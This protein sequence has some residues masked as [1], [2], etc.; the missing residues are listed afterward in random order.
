MRWRPQRVKS[1]STTKKKKKQDLES[2]WRRK[3]RLTVSAAC[4]IDFGRASISLVDENSRSHQKGKGCK[5]N[6]LQRQGKRFFQTNRKQEMKVKRRWQNEQKT[7]F[8]KYGL[9]PCSGFHFLN[10]IDCLTLSENKKKIELQASWNFLSFNVPFLLF[11]ILVVLYVMR[12]SE[13]T[14]FYQKGFGSSLGNR[15]SPGQ[16]WSRVCVQDGKGLNKITRGALHSSVARLQAVDLHV[17]CCSYACMCGSLSAGA[18][19]CWK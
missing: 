7:A 14:F 11:S 9:S 12:F 1:N 16:L 19:N 8:V 15:N 17:Y 3:E 5:K 4:R 6:P 10:F 18:S 2:G 13:I